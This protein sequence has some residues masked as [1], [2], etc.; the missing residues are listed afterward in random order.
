VEST[1]IPEGKLNDAAAPAPSACPCLPDPARV[2]TSPSEEILLSEVVACIGDID[3]SGGMLNDAAVPTPSVRPCFFE[4]A[5]VL[6]TP[7]GVTLRIRLFLAVRH[8]DVPGGIHRDTS[9]SAERSGPAL[10]IVSRP[11]SQRRGSRQCGYK[12]V[13]HHRIIRT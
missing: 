7:S 1:A 3:A 4:P 11:D 2:V 8:V 13:G 12:A 9:R 5:R 10:P 6:T